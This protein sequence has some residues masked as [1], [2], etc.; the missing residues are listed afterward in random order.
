[1]SFVRVGAVVVVVGQAFGGLASCASRSAP[2]TPVEA[3]L[4]VPPLDVGSSS[5]QPGTGSDRTVRFG[6]PPATVGASWAVSTTAISTSSDPA[7]DQ[8]SSYSSSFRVT[9]LAVDGPAATK[10][11]LHFD[12]NQN[13]YQGQDTPTVIHGKDYVVDARAPHVFDP[14]GTAAAEEETQRVLDA[15]PDIGTRSRVDEVLPESMRIGDRRDDLAAAVVRI[16]HPRAWTLTSGSASLA[17]VE[18]GDAVFTVKLEA[19]SA[20][21]MT[22]A[23]AG[24]L[25]ARL[26]DSHLSSIT[27]DGSYEPRTSSADHKGTIRY[28]RVTSD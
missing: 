19:S 12:K 15:F 8:V 18:G 26:R 23:V 24:E 11:K 9:V 13:E 5:G 7:G 27:L 16:M 1:M 21:G 3:S 2:V 10:V 20:S 22:M 28:R 17:R 14:S 6:H 4:V 25:R